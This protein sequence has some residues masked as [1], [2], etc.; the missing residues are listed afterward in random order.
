[1]TG[2]AGPVGC[3]MKLAV[4]ERLWR[5]EYPNLNAGPTWS[6]SES[7]PDSNQFT[8]GIP[9]GSLLTSSICLSLTL[10]LDRKTRLSC[11]NPNDVA[12][13][14]RLSRGHESRKV[15]GV[16]VDERMTSAYILCTRVDRK[17]VH[18]TFT[19]RTQ[20]KQ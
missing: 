8:H 18:M 1:M 20:V 16:T 15:N 9:S 5:T 17:S 14:R 19:Q 11:Y 12:W 7:H 2:Y 3:H 6:D 10:E 13:G 4:V